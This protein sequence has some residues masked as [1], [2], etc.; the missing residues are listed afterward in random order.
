MSLLTFLKLGVLK[1]YV[2]DSFDTEHAT[3]FDDDNA[4]GLGRWGDPN[5]NSQITT[6]GFKDVVREYPS[7]H[8]IRRTYTLRPLGNIPNKA[9]V[10][11][12]QAPPVDPN[13]MANESFTK[14]N[15]DYTLN[16]F[17]GDF[18]GFQTYLEGGRVCDCLVVTLRFFRHP[19]RA[20]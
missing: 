4:S 13:I 20:I 11:D 8:R 19:Q 12:P 9:F 17:S 14:A 10:N 15:Y 18:L 16:G 7:R 1:D 2:A 3:I 6:G 5:D